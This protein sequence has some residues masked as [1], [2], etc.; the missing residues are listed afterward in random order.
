MRSRALASREENDWI[1]TCAMYSPSALGSRRALKS[2]TASESALLKALVPR[3]IR[4][5]SQQGEQY[6]D[7]Y[8]LEVANAVLD[9]AAAYEFMSG[10]LDDHG[11][12]I[13]AFAAK[14]T[15]EYTGR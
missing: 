2:L 15:P 13:E 14:E 8:R 11:I 12:G 9:R 10:T 3:R 1:W 4:D 7:A 6:V 5:W